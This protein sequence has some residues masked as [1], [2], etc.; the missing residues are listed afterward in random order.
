[1]LTILQCIDT[2]S[3][4][5]KWGAFLPFPSLFILLLVLSSNVI[6][7]DVESLRWYPVFVLNV[8][9]FSTLFMHIV[10]EGILA[11]VSCF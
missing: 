4:I 6:V 3:V 8:I 7:S 11:A 5:S 2:T 9:Q 10:I 1:M